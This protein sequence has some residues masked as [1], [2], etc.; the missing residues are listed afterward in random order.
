[1][2]YSKQNTTGEKNT[3]LNRRSYLRSVPIL[4]ALAAL[5]TLARAELVD[6]GNG[7]FEDTTSGLVW[8]KNWMST[9]LKTVEEHRA[10]ADALVLGGSD[11]WRLP[12]ITEF[13]S[14]GTTYAQWYSG[15]FPL[16]GYQ[17]HPGPYVSTDMYTLGGPECFNFSEKFPTGPCGYLS[18]SVQG[19]YA[20]A[21]RDLAAPVPEP[22]T[23][24]LMVFGLGSIVCAA[25]RRR[26]NQ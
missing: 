1:M 17:T 26:R 15:L 21:V 7:T 8:Q 6:L 5:G 24:A 2:T 25:R 16:L 14:L 10:W 13:L 12:T 11:S 4:V 18:Y 20:V 23:Y 9:S 22:S 19:G 3:H